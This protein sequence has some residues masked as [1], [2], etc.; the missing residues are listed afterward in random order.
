VSIKGDVFVGALRSEF[1]CRHIEHYHGTT[2]ITAT[3]QNQE[4][5]SL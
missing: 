1:W 3:F 2:A 4:S 5:V